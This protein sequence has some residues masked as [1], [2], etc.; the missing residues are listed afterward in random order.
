A[1][2]QQ[3]AGKA[4]LILLGAEEPVTFFAYPD[5]PSQLVPDGTEVQVL[6]GETDDATGALAALAAE[7]GCADE[8][9]PRPGGDPAERP[10]GELNAWTVSLAVGALLPENAIVVDEA[11]TSSLSLPMTT[12]NAPRHDWLTLT[13]GSIGFGLPAAVGAA[14]AAPDRKVL[15]LQA[16]G[17]AMYTL[18]A[19]W[20][21]AR[22]ELDVTVVIYNNASYEILKMELQRVGAEGSGPR[23][24]DLFDLGRPRLDFTHLARGMGVDAARATTAE[25]FTDLLEAA[26]ETPGP[27]LVE[28]MIPKLF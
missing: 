8:D 18:Q 12:A 7:L 28:A 4:H 20:T 23:A 6:A 24:A 27:S 11:I 21:M 13:G 10:T 16:D 17:S 5:K 19:L 25:G 14:I 3:L 1:S 9:P 26:L 15:A 2:S 22:E